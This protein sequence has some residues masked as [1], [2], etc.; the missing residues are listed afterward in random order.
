MLHITHRDVLEESSWQCILSLSR[1]PHHM[2]I[3][4]AQ[5]VC[6]GACTEYNQAGPYWKPSPALSFTHTLILMRAMRMCRWSLKCEMILL[7]CR[8]CGIYFPI[9]LPWQVCLMGAGVF[10]GV[11]LVSVSI[12][13]WARRVET[14][15]VQTSISSSSSA[16]C[17]LTPRNSNSKILQIF[18]LSSMYVESLDSI[19]SL[20]YFGI[21]EAVPY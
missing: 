18:L 11:H 2:E 21:T 14:V 10:W 5:G 6:Q 20:L 3:W 9:K 8:L 7:S 15:H 19:G 1:Q 17:H 12:C 13:Y 16:F 4:E